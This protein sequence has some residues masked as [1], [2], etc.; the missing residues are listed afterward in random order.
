[1]KSFTSIFIACLFFINNTKAQNSGLT[2]SYE[3]ST[4]IS[5]ILNG[6]NYD[7][8]APVMAFHNLRAGAHDLKV[9]KWLQMGNSVVKQPV[10]DGQIILEHAQMTEIQINRFNQIVLRGKSRVETNNN[11]TAQQQNQP[12]QMPGQFN[13]PMQG[14]FNQPYM[15]PQTFPAPNPELVDGFTSVNTTRQQMSNEMLS[16]QIELLRDMPGERERLQ[17]AKSL[18]SISTISS[19]QLAEMMLLFENE[20]NRIRLADYG[21]DYVTDR[22]NF[23]IVYQTLRHPRSFNRLSRRTR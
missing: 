17:T 9:F 6:T 7:D 4:F 2:I 22:Q 11:T 10:Y 13:Q 21:Y 18:V 12:M 20:Q 14:Q 8:A 3:D 19:A 1:M 5:V 15:H 23:S 16:A